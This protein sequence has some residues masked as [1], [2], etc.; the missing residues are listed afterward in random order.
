MVI[1]WRSQR[2][3]WRWWRRQKRQWWWCRAASR[4]A[5]AVYNQQLRRLQQRRLNPPS[6]SSS[7]IPPPPLWEEVK[8]IFVEVILETMLTP[9]IMSPRKLSRQMRTKM[10]HL[11]VCASAAVCNQRLL[12][13]N[14]R[15]LKTA[16]AAVCRAKLQAPAS[17]APTGKSQPQKSERNTFDSAEEIQL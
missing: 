15:R 11:C 9:L 2:K 17:L 4:C 5:A 3:G 10:M 12:Q 1:S 6:A 7:H 8:N 13:F 14:S 16:A